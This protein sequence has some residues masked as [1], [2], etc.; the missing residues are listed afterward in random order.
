[1]NSPTAI[2]VAG[3]FGP[4][5][6]VLL[7]LH[8]LPVAAVWAFTAANESFMYTRE[9]VPV[10]TLTMCWGGPLSLAGAVAGLAAAAFGRP[11]WRKWWWACVA[12]NVAG[13]VI[14]CGGFLG[15]MG[16]GG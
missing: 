15:L 9:S 12:V 6:A 10:Y 4:C 2:G 13:L 1:M 7:S 5:L 14:N 8:N 16:G 3:H 11:A